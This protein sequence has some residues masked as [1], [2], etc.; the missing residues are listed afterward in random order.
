MMI[1]TSKNADDY[2]IKFENKCMIITIKTQKPKPVAAATDNGYSLYIKH[3]CNLQFSLAIYFH[4]SNYL[5]TISN[6]YWG[7]ESS[8]YLFYILGLRFSFCEDDHVMPAK[9]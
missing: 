4:K 8:A 5:I 6:K 2:T 9:I 7:K 3:L 1:N